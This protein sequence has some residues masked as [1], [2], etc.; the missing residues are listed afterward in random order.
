MAGFATSAMTIALAAAAAQDPP[1]R[2]PPPLLAPAPRPPGCSTP[3]LP[4][5]PAPR[6]RPAP[7]TPVPGPVPPTRAQPR[8]PLYCYVRPLDYPRSALRAAEQGVVVFGLAVAPDG[9]VAD[10]T[11]RASSGS[12]ALDAITCRIF[13]TRARFT[14][15]RDARGAPTWDTFESRI[16]WQIR[17]PLPE[18]APPPPEGVEGKPEG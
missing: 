10:C 7:F 8:Q 14:P 13:R 1:P 2:P 6:S 16:T 3:P 11:I 15:A 17:G 9:R 12:A 5:G 4:L 18:P